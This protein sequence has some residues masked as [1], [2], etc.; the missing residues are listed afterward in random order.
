[1]SYARLGQES[2]VYVFSTGTFLCCHFCE[3]QARFSQTTADMLEH[4]RGHQ[5]RGDKVPQ[6]AFDR[7]IADQ[8]ENDLMF[9]A[10]RDTTTSKRRGGTGTARA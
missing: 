8:E 5:E 6:S 10:A 9:A 7:L 1:M 3:P 2:D 4:L